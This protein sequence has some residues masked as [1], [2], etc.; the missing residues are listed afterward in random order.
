MAH[1]SAEGERATL[2]LLAE[3]Y[4][5]IVD[6]REA[7]AAEQQAHN[8]TRTDLEQLR[9]TILADATGPEDD[10]LA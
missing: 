9:A 4:A 5:T 10:S 1:I 8:A 3:Q 7:L 6:L 2:A